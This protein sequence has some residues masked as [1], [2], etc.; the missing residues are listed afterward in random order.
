MLALRAITCKQ[1]VIALSNVQ[2][3]ASLAAAYCVRAFGFA[4]TLE[5]IASRIV[6]SVRGVAQRDQDTDVEQL[7]SHGSAS[8]S[9]FSSSG[10]T[11]AAPA[12]TASRGTPFRICRRVE[13]GLSA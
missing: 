13:A 1:F 10:V 4:Q 2:L 6:L 9:W 7:R 11:G 12:R 5:T 3:K 8:R